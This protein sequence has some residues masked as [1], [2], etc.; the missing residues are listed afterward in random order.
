MLIVSLGEAD[1]GARARIVRIEGRSVACLI[2][3][4]ESLMPLGFVRPVI[5]LSLHPRSDRTKDNPAACYQ[6]SPKRHG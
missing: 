6:P 3:K 5:Q 1:Y 4:F 2:A